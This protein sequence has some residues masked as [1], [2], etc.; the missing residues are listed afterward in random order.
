MLDKK[1]IT[2]LGEL[3]DKQ[4]IEA[5]GKLFNNCIDNGHILDSLEE[6]LEGRME[7]LNEL[8]DN[9]LDSTGGSD[10]GYRLYHRDAETA[11]EVRDEITYFIQ[12]N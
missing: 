7:V 12:N 10:L 4:T 5:L 2:S 8:L 9:E 11:K 1:L 3:D 6:A